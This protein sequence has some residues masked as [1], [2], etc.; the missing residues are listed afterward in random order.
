M[1]GGL[2]TR[3]LVVVGAAVTAGLAGTAVALGSRGADAQ[4]L[5]DQRHPPNLRPADVER[6]V[7]TAPDPATGKGRGV[8]AT[9]K[10]RG[11]G[12]L[13]NPWSCVVRFPSGKRYRLNVRVQQDGYY[14][15]AYVGVKGAA[16]TGCCID[17]PGTR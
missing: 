14:D 1:I 5:Q 15:G 8:A 13:G 2:R 17:L 7:R 6:V 16:A 4:F 11:S 9:C 12:Q 10:R 3:E